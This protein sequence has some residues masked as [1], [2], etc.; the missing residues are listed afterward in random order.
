[1]VGSLE[2]SLSGPDLLYL[3][4]FAV[5]EAHIQGHLLED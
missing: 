3:M 2:P 5:Q 4:Y 1:M